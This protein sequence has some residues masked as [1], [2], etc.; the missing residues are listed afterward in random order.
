MLEL[1]KKYNELLSRYNKGL[2]MM[3]EVKD[4]KEKENEYL[5]LLKNI[6]LEMNNVLMNIGEYSDEETVNGFIL[7]VIED[8]IDIEKRKKEKNELI[9]SYEVNNE[10]ITLTPQIVQ[11]YLVGTSA[12]ITIP[13]FKLFA[14]L[15]KARKLNP[16]LKE[17][18]C[19][20]YSNNL[21]AT[22]VVGKDAVLKRAVLNPNYNG[23]KSGIIVSDSNG[24]I[25]ERKGTFKLSR[26]TLVGGWAE[27]FRKDWQNSVYCSVSLEEVIQKKSNGQPNSNWEKQPATMI[28]KVAKVRALREA[29]VEDLGGMYEAEE[30]N[31][32]LS[33]NMNYV[34]QSREV[35]D[36]L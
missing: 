36:V 33:N 11:D 12:K 25:T 7:E 15:C 8:A 14:E 27:V 28:E 4:N 32:E 2:A 35:Q 16:F 5:E 6:Q 17:A 31:I 19:I 21:P 10:E 30:M 3:A 1:K 22:I 34:E 13:E 9:V 29:F 20:K 26:E 23:I 24:N 18:Y